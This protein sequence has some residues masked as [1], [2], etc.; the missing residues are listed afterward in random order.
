MTKA[1]A[2]AVLAEK[3]M[4]WPNLAHWVKLYPDTPFC[5]PGRPNELWNPWT[6]NGQAI[7]LAEAWRVRKM[8]KVKYLIDMPYWLVKSPTTD[9][10]DDLLAND[11]YQAELWIG[12]G[13]EHIDFTVSAPTLSVALTG[14]VCKAVGI[15]VKE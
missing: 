9:D 15:E 6:D 4:G 8:K 11:E 3:V 5:V 12:Q 13:N 2:L 14:A 7:D 10:P 1:A